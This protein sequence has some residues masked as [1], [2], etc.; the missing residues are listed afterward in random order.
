MAPGDYGYGIWASYLS[1]GSLTETGFDDPTGGSGGTFGYGELMTGLAGGTGVLPYLSFGGALK[2]ARQD[3]D[4]YS[5]SGV[6]GDLSVCFKAYS[7]DLEVSSRPAVYT[8]YM[9]RNILITR[10]GDDGGEAPRNS[11]VGVA[12]EFPG[13]DLVVGLAFYFAGGG[14]REVRCGLEADLSP[15]FELRLGYRKRTGRMSDQ[16]NE[17]PWERGLIAGFGLG[18]GPVRLDYTYEDASPL[19]NIHRFAITSTLSGNQGN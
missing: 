11:E 15:D 17:L 4:D 9:A 7:P 14:R 12:L 16:A 5:T 18:L 13:G 2:L 10:W 1:S 3:L 19:D 8:S 6:F